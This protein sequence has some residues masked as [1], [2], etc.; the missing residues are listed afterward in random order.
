MRPVPGSRA[1]RASGDV[2]L[3]D[4]AQRDLDLTQLI[5]QALYMPQFEEVPNT[6]NTL[7]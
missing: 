3:R 4:F 7:H 5:R 6:T 1:R 2:L